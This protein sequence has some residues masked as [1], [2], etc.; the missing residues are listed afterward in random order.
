MARK[1]ATVEEIGIR[2]DVNLLPEELSPNPSQV[3]RWFTNN[4][5]QGIWGLLF[6]WTGRKIKPVAV[7]DAGW[8]KVAA[9][10]VPLEHMQVFSGTASDI[11]SG[12]L[13]FVNTVSRIDVFVWD[14]DL[15]VQRA[16]PGGVYEAEFVVPAN[17]MYSFDVITEKMRVKNATAGQVARYQIVG[18]Y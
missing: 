9:S 17:T 3:R 6:G 1:P 4:I 11:W 15:T 12:E 2:L 7:T 18:W 13:V 14:Y 8:L 5:L 16:Y 10:S